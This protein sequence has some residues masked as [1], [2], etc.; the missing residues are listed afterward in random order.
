MAVSVELEDFDWDEIEDFAKENLE[1]IKV[2]DIT[3][4]YL[5]ERYDIFDFL[6]HLG[7]L[8]IPDFS[9]PNN[10]IITVDIYKK[11]Y[12]NI[13]KIPINEL[14]NLLNKYNCI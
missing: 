2:D 10:S 14:E 6:E 13:E 11:L 5:H 12:R 8:E 7:G 3:L 9:Y 4:E 1:M